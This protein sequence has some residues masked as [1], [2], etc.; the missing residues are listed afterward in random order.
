VPVALAGAAVLVDVARFSGVPLVGYL[1]EVFVW[2]ALQQVGIEYA[3]GR[4][5]RLSTS[6]SALVGL[7]GFAV[8]ALLVV[9]GPYPAS[10]VGLPGQAVSNMSP[11][12]LCLLTLGIG[13][14]GLLFACRRA[15][16]AF[17]RRPRV[18]AL[19]R[20]VGPRCMTVYLWHMSAMIIVAGVTVV[21]FGYATPAAGSLGWLIATPLW[22][23]ALALVLRGL[24]VAFGRFE[25]IRADVVHGP[26][27]PRLAAGLVLLAAGLLDIAARGFVIP[28]GHGLLPAICL[29]PLPAIVAVLGSLAITRSYAQQRSGSVV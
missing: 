11:A 29:G 6:V 26:S 27:A 9:A 12:T 4:F 15:I 7:G 23:G 20:L 8:T 2:L 3:A 13:Q 1:N 10:M 5:S 18:A 25:T 24:L 19:Q 17:G 21:G 22:I 14:L 28:S 16:V